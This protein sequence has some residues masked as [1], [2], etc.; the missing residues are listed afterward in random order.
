ME[1]RDRL[2]CLDEL[3]AD[4]GGADNG[5]H[6]NGPCGLLSEHLRAARSALLGSRPVEYGLSLELAKGSVAC[7]ADKN[8]RNRTTAMVRNLIDSNAPPD[9]SSRAPGTESTTN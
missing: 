3:I 4:L 8:A 2:K 1:Q 9:G 6:T 7:V 5:M